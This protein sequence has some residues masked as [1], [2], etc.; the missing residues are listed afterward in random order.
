MVF[1]W[2]KRRQLMDAIINN[3]LAR[4]THLLNGGLDPN[5]GQNKVSLSISRS[6]GE[7]EKMP[8]LYAAIDFSSEQMVELLLDHG[9]NPNTPLSIGPGLSLRFY[10]DALSYLISTASL[11]YMGK[12]ELNDVFSQK[13]FNMYVALR[14][15]MQANPCTHN[16]IEE[17]SHPTLVGCREW[18]Q[19]QRIAESLQTPNTQ[20]VQKKRRM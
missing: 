10:S 6:Q 3:D 19:A 15:K 13:H 18:E 12:P 8:P 9:A 7:K 1:T 14:Q 4:A 2:F 16:T 11:V 5:F 20:S 17:S